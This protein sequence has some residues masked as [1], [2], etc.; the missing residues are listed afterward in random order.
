VWWWARPQTNCRPIMQLMADQHPATA[1]ATLD[2]V[3]VEVDVLD[4]EAEERIHWA[5][6]AR[7][8]SRWPDETER[9]L[10]LMQGFLLRLRLHR[11]AF[12]G[13]AEMVPLLRSNGV[14][15]RVVQTDAYEMLRG[16]TD[17]ESDERKQKWKKGKKGKKRRKESKKGSK[18]RRSKRGKHARK[19][20]GSCSESESEGGGDSSDSDARQAVPWDAH[21]PDETS[22]A[23]AAPS[24]V[25]I[26]TDGECRWR[27]RLRWRRARFHR[28]PEDAL[29]RGGAW[30][31][32]GFAMLWTSPKEL[33]DH[34]ADH[35]LACWLR[36]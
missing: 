34:L 30:A 11:R 1:T 12:G 8:L 4:A 10:P 29:T 6:I 18:E 33:C 25:K 17:S 24:G 19:S 23:A 9:L 15:V 27:L 35:A 14:E 26:S 36:A 5:I 22:V 13:I 16:D 31:S 7:A 2:A 3:A 20:R 32:A 21:A 28:Q